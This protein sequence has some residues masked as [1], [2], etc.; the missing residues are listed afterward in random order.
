MRKFAALIF[1][2]TVLA[3]LPSFAADTPRT[4][5]TAPLPKDAVLFTWLGLDGDDTGVPVDVSACAQL[6]A[7]VYSSAYGSSTVTVEGSND[8]LS[9][10]AEYVGLTDPQGNAISKTADGIEAV[11][12]HPKWFKPRTASGTAASV[13]VGLLCQKYR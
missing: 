7:H 8:V 9:T 6:T 11:E 5:T 13:A 2:A 10:S 3:A 12:E 4:P 1:T